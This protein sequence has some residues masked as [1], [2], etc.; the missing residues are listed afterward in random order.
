MSKTR[1]RRAARRKTAR[2]LRDRYPGTREGS[3]PVGTAGSERDRRRERRPQRRR[4]NQDDD[5]EDVYDGE[6]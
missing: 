6:E 5:T 2:I 1:S 4:L 3:L